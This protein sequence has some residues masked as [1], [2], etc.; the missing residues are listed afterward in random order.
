[1]LQVSLVDESL[2]DI[3]GRTVRQTWCDKRRMMGDHGMVTQVDACVKRL[4]RPVITLLHSLVN[5]GYRRAP[6]RVSGS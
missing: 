3:T 4:P 6:V 1:M 2:A 5:A